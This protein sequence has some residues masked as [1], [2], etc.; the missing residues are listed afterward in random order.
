M[1]IEF[2]LDCSDLDRTA[3]FWQDAAGLAM[4]G[5][6]EGRYVSLTG[7]GVHLTLQ[8]VPQA[9]AGKNRMHID[10]LVRDVEGEVVRLEA[11]GAARLTPT[12]HHEF[13]QTWFVMT[14]PEGNEFCVAHDPDG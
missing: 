6:I 5:T 4:T 14:D 1:R 3:L 2:T 9:K 7:L 8:W 11:L 10:L 12:A 13:G